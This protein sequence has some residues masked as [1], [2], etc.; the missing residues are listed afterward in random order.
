MKKRPAKSIFR[1]AL[2]ASGGARLFDDI[3][4]NVFNIDPLRMEMVEVSVTGQQRKMSNVSDGG[5]P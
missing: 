1:G 3:G 2:L 5:D 4:I